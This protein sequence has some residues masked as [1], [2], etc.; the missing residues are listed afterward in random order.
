M[1]VLLDWP[2]DIAASSRMAVS[3]VEQP[4]A[5]T[6]FTAGKRKRQPSAQYTDQ[7]N[8]IRARSAACLP[9]ATSIARLPRDFAPAQQRGYRTDED[10]AP[11]ERRSRKPEKVIMCV[12]LRQHSGH[13]EF[14]HI[15]FGQM[16]TVGKH[17]GGQRALMSNTASEL[18]GY[19]AS[20]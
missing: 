1:P 6:A 2:S 3:L 4:Q 19:G 11:D 10:T 16:W 5:A 15:L 18:A 13:V 12:L 20:T 14:R 17:R 8:S 7:R 9:L